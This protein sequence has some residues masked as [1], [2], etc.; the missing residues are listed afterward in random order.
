MTCLL[1]LPLSPSCLL[2]SPAHMTGNC[3]QCTAIDPHTLHGV[4]DLFHSLSLLFTNE[5][6]HRIFVSPPSRPSAMSRILDSDFFF[7]LPF[8][9]PAAFSAFHPSSSPLPVCK[10]GS[11]EDRS[12]CCSWCCC[13]SQKERYKTQDERD[14]LLPLLASVMPAFHDEILP[15]L[16]SSPHALA[17][18]PCRI[19][20]CAAERCSCPITLG[21]KGGESKEEKCSGIPWEERES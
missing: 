14:A 9:A 17:S 16:L 19:R 8:S 3:R 18:L 4:S 2:R 11:K 5:N 1:S 20:G 7:L 15:S 6:S 21:L 10:L 12:S 13:C